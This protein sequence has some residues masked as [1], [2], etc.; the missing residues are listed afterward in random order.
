MSAAAEREV[1]LLDFCQLFLMSG[2]RRTPTSDLSQVLLEIHEA[3][4]GSVD[5]Q[6]RSVQQEEQEATTCPIS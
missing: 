6:L 1:F 5:Q 2:I 4:R 3:G